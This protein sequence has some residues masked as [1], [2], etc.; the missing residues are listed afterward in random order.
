MKQHL[1]IL[2]L[3]EAESLTMEQSDLLAQKLQG[4]VQEVI[5]TPV[6]DTVVEYEWGE[7]V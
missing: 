1:D 4:V 2:I 5:G 3:T 7:P 6:K